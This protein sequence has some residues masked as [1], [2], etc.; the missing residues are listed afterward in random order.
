[1]A[2]STRRRAIATSSIVTPRPGDAVDGRPLASTIRHRPGGEAPGHSAEVSDH[3][4]PG[5]TPRPMRN[6]CAAA[7]WVASPEPSFGRHGRS[8]TPLRR[9]QP[10]LSPLHGAELIFPLLGTWAGAVITPP[11]SILP[12]WGP[13]AT[14]RIGWNEQSPGFRRCSEHQARRRVVQ[15]VADLDASHG[16]PLKHGSPCLHPPGACGS[17]DR[18]DSAHSSEA[19]D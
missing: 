7:C 9:F 3:T 8:C 6:A 14:A 5:H 19:D 13:P 11:I 1:L 12:A 18:R 15:T 2:I 4:P 10:I 17:S 16:R